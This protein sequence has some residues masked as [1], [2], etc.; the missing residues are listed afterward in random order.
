MIRRAQDTLS[1]PS[2]RVGREKLNI[3]ER[4]ESKQSIIHEVK[5]GMK[6]MRVQTEEKVVESAAEDLATPL[7]PGMQPMHGS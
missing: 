1:S 5:V 2:A 3:E 4:E 6:R 7:T